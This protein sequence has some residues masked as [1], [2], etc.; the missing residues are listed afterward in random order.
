[1]GF[2]VVPFDYNEE[3]HSSVVPICI[4]DMDCEG[5]PIHREWVEHGVVPVA[6]PLRKIAKRVLNDAWR[7]SE[8]TERAVHSLSRK[9]GG[10]LGDEPSRRVLN[11]ARWHAEDLRVGGRRA[12]RKTE[13]ELF[14][15]TLETLPDRYDLFSDLET[16]ETLTRLMEALDREGSHDICEMASMIMWDCAAREFENRFQRSRNTLSQRFYR[17]VRRVAAATRITW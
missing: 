2:I 17:G 11:R 6:D 1:M 10:I 13:V 8:I 15:V 9:H 7:V 4:A 3:L 14:A 12:R 16:K 5:N